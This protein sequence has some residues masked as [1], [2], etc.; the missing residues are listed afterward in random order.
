MLGVITQTAAF[1]LNFLFLFEELVIDH[2]SEG[3]N[4]CEETILK[5]ILESVSQNREKVF[6]WELGTWILLLLHFLHFFFFFFL[7]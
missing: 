3:Q 6:L 4:S 1:F 2:C 7:R 5:D